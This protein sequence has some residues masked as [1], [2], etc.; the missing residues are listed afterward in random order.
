[1]FNVDILFILDLRDDF[2]MNETQTLYE[3]L[4]KDYVKAFHLGMRIAH[5]FS[6]LDKKQQYLYT[7][8]MRHNKE[9]IEEYKDQIKFW[10]F[11]FPKESENVNVLELSEFVFEN[12]IWNPDTEDI[13]KVKVALFLGTLTGKD[14]DFTE[15]DK[16][17]ENDN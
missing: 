4:G 2:V 15:E 11:K 17:F 14:A 10:I 5:W 3:F 16:S 12:L 6:L 1:M 7:K 9:E 13:D 8:P